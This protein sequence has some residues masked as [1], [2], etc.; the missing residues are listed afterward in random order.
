[1]DVTARSASNILFCC[2]MFQSRGPDFLPGRALSG[3][4]RGAESEL[5]WRYVHPRQDRGLARSSRRGRR[6]PDPA[7]EP[8]HERVRARIRVHV[9]RR[10]NR[11]VA[12]SLLLSGVRAN[13]ADTSAVRDRHA[14]LGHDLLASPADVG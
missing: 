10:V 12:R 9:W 2:K 4:T 11:A 8:L 13:T 3:D 5:G 6:W 14:A 7:Q 1:M